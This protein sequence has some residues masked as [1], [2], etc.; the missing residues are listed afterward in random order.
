MKDAETLV[1]RRA[2]RALK[3]EVEAPA[4]A[5][6]LAFDWWFLAIADTRFDS[7]RCHT[8]SAVRLSATNGVATP[9][10]TETSMR[11][12]DAAATHPNV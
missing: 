11:G 3:A 5:A 9:T 8:T 7:S 2:H 10:A 12:T 4:C 6:A 1:V